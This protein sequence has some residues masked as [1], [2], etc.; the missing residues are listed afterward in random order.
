MLRAVFE[1]IHATPPGRS[2]QDNL[3]EPYAGFPVS[4]RAATGRAL[5]TAIRADIGESEAYKAAL[6]QRHEIGLQR[7]MKANVQGVDFITAAADPAGS[8][9]I[10]VTD[11]KTTTVGNQSYTKK[12]YIPGTWRAE[13]EAAVARMRLRCIQGLATEEEI[14]CLED[15]IRAAL[16]AT[17]IILRYVE[18]DY[19]PLGQGRVT[20]R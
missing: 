17:H 12:S 16:R 7:P 2:N 11:V 3:P 15:Q 9:Q 20:F 6:F 14:R 18:V 4:A 10:F 1:S 8:M 19:S 5:A 13:V